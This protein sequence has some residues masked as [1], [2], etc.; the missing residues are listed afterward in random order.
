[1]RY[2]LRF[3]HPHWHGSGKPVYDKDDTSTFDAESDAAAREYAA[4]LV[5]EPQR[6]LEINGVVYPARVVDLIELRKVELV[7]EAPPAIPATHAPMASMPEQ[8]SGSFRVTGAQ[9]RH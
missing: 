9:F 5:A 8:A 7:A 1:M 2:R 4:K 3:Q 6:S